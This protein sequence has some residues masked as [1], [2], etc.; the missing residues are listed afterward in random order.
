[1]SQYILDLRETLES[2]REQI[3]AE[4]REKEEKARLTDPT[5]EGKRANTHDPTK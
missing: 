3:L 2:G 4:K 5:A 1:V